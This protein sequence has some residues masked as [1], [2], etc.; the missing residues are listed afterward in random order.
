[1]DVYEYYVSD[2]VEDVYEEA[3]KS[4]PRWDGE[5]VG[6]VRRY[7]ILKIFKKDANK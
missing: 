6:I 7:P 2:N 3:I 1:M 4:V 5:F